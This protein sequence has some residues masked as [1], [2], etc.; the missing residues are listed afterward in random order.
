LLEEQLEEERVEWEANRQVERE[1]AV[2]KLGEVAQKN[3]GNMTNMLKTFKKNSGDTITLP[4]FSEHLRRRKL[5]KAMPTEDQELVFEQLKASARG[6]VNAGSLSRTVDSKMGADGAQDGEAAEIAAFLAESIK[7]AREA[8]EKEGDKGKERVVVAGGEDMMRKAIGQ[9]SMGIDAGTEEMDNVMDDLFHKKHTQKSHGKFS[10]YLRLT[11]LNLKAIPFY[12]L[13]SDQLDNMK[14]H[15][16]NIE[17][18]IS[19]PSVAGRLAQLKETR[20]HQVEED[21]HIHDKYR[22]EEER[23]A[24]L[25]VLTDQYRGN[26][27]RSSGFSSR[28]MPPISSPTGSLISTRFDSTLNAELNAERSGPAT[29]FSPI[30]PYNLTAAAAMGGE[31]DQSMYNST[32]GEYFPPLRY[33]TNQPVTRDNLGDADAK[34]K[35][36]N[37]RRERRAI[38]TKANQQVTS[39]RLELQALDNLARQLRRNQS[40]NEDQIRYQSTIFLHDLKCFKKQPL[41]RMARKPNLTKSDRMWGGQ[42]SFESKGEVQTKAESSDLSTT[43]RDSFQGHVRTEPTVDIESKVHKMFGMEQ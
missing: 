28:E 15:A 16:V 1:A 22:V 3:Y 17:K 32:Y 23:L 12:D 30:K 25:R 6:S 29:P 21:L 2:E 27:E 7:A 43:F 8:K 20:R 5:D 31:L 26:S 39:D 4:E 10:R 38:R 34:V 42:M 37:E 14:K 19:S 33:E 24:S 35:Q 9:K 41:T 13:R 11:N 36:R 18:I 40:V